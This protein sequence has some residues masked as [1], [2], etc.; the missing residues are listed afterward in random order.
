MLF[1]SL[2]LG[3][4]QSQIAAF[5]HCSVHVLENV[6]MPLPFQNLTKGERYSADSILTWLS[7]RKSD[8]VSILVG[9]T[10]E[11]I[12]IADKDENGH[13]RKPVSKYA[14]WGILGLGDCP[15]SVC[16]I[17]DAR[18]RL[19]SGNKYNHRLK[20][21][22]IHEIGHNLGLPH[23]KSPHCIMNDANEQIA[24]VD[25][26]GSDFCESC[27]KILTSNMTFKSKVSGYV[28]QCT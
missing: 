14:V 8:S 12:Y 20:T 26:S 18:F 10:S 6:D 21:I 28:M 23:C 4:I 22:V 5:F 2:M 7:S 13:I 3:F 27:K 17:S 15:G 11:D 25:S 16:V 24:T 19:S 9:L 1:R